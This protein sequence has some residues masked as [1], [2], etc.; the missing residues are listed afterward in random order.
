MLAQRNFPYFL[1]GTAK[2]GA[3]PGLVR[4]PS[5]PA[6]HSRRMGRQE[7]WIAGC[8]KAAVL[9]CGRVVT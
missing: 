6:A 2:V 8:M 5:L 3:V 4:L 9:A 7:I 1:Q